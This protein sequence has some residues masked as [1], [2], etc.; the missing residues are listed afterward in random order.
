[1]QRGWVGTCVWSQCVALLLAV[2][3]ERYHEE[4]CTGHAWGTQAWGTQD[5]GFQ[6]S[7]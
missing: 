5:Q 6:M 7:C 2:T 4:I 1:M 3:G